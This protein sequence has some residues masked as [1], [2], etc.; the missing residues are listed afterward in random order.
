MTTYERTAYR[1]GT[2]AP[3]T[4]I[5][6]R[7]LTDPDHQVQYTVTVLLSGVEHSATAADA[8]E[9]LS[10]VR[11]VLDREGWL[12]GVQG[13]RI[14]VWASSM[15]RQQGG[16]MRAYRLRRGRHPRFDD[17]VDVFAPADERLGTV[18]AQRAYV[19]AEVEDKR[20]DAVDDI[21]TVTTTT[22]LAPTPSMDGRPSLLDRLTGRSQPARWAAPERWTAVRATLGDVLTPAEWAEAEVLAGEVPTGRYQP[23]THRITRAVGSDDEGIRWADLVDVAI[24]PD[25]TIRVRV[26]RRR[27]VERPGAPFDVVLDTRVEGLPPTEFRPGGLGMTTAQHQ[28]PA[29]WEYLR[30]HELV[31]DDAMQIM[32]WPDH[33]RVP[34]GSDDDQGSTT[35]FWGRADGATWTVLV[36]AAGHLR[37]TRT[38]PQPSPDEA[39]I[40]AAPT[41]P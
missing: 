39:R 7:D 14:D 1:N 13:A 16:G 4:V 23:S 5:V 8:F 24:E 32:F 38:Q 2:R 31:P 6:D 37:I 34:T 27:Y 33:G 26:F 30:D 11:E 20:A 9:A 28:V 10:L 41:T 25:G 15:A 35:T 17:L 40:D 3:A 21:E 36:S 12:L 18:A 19:G 29:L 22:T